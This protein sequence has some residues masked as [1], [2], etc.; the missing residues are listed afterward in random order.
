MASLFGRLP[1][2]VQSDSTW[3]EDIDS[4]LPL[5]VVNSITPCRAPS[6]TVALTSES[7]ITLKGASLLPP[8]DTLVTLARWVP[9]MV[10]R[11]PTGPLCGMIPEIVLFP[12]DRPSGNSSDV[13]WLFWGPEDRFW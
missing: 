4:T 13:T 7:L 11:P 9:M 10:T 1:R 2:P 6:G 3:N 5:G 12:A 8:N